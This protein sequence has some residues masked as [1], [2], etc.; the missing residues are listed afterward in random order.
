M[1]VVGQAVNSPSDKMVMIIRRLMVLLL[2]D[3][4]GGY[5]TISVYEECRG[6][7]AALVGFALDGVTQL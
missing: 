7:L 3:L 2:V 1:A 5:S 4:T 6:T